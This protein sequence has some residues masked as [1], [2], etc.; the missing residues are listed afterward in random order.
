MT[1]YNQ[2]VRKL[3]KDPRAIMESMTEERTNILHAMLGINDEILE[4]MTALFNRDMENLL[5]ELGDALFYTEALGDQIGVSIEDIQYEL[6]NF[7]LED[8][9]DYP[10]LVQFANDAATFAKRIGIYNKEFDN[11]DLRL[12]YVKLHMLYRHVATEFEGEL[13]EVF[14]D[15]HYDYIQET[16]L[17]P[18]LMSIFELIQE[19][20]SI[21]LLKGKTARY[22]SGSYSDEQ[23]N[24]RADKGDS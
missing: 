6:N 11:A 13:R 3:L 2:M 19:A 5:E 23:A 9:S 22:K 12:F 16:G 21:K 17:K 10:T 8:L 4:M 18:K 7:T 14:V 24:A 20:N 1:E 15:K